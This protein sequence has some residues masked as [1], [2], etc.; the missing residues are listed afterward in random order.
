MSTPK[1]DLLRQIKA[2][3]EEKGLSREMTALSK[4]LN[5]RG[6]QPI[7]GGKW[8]ESNAS[9]LRNFWVNNKGLLELDEH[10]ERA[11]QETLPIEPQLSDERASH[12]AD[13]VQE[14]EGALSDEH[15]ER[16]AHIAEHAEH[17]ECD[18]PD[19]HIPWTE[20]EARMREIAREVATAVMNEMSVNHEMNAINMNHETPGPD[21]PPEPE[22]RKGQKGRKQ[23]RTYER[24]TVSLDANLAKLFKAEMKRRRVSSGRLMDIIC[25]NYFGRPRLSFEV[26]EHQD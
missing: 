15:D 7:K 17:E 11:S 25:W 8:D 18:E 13:N 14:P 5:A 10:E 24:L 23:N 22:Y 2:V 9:K 4:E 26:G 16:A 6:I 12:D 20:M 3:M 19:A 21:M 1:V